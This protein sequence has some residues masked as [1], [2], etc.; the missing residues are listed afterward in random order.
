MHLINPVPCF[1][2]NK[3]T[4]HVRLPLGF[5]V[6]G[7]CPLL[8]LWCP[9]EK[10]RYAPAL[11]HVGDPNDSMLSSERVILLTNMYWKSNYQNPISHFAAF[12]QSY[13]NIVS[14]IPKNF[15]FHRLLF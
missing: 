11:R 4:S 12:W 14:S 9:C 2:L 6:G 3:K 7:L 5:K 1:L 8:G 15:P 13:V 10:K